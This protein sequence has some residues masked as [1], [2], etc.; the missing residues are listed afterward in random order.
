M[1]KNPAYQRRIDAGAM[2][3]LGDVKARRRLASV[4]HGALIALA[5]ST[6]VALA[7]GGPPLV[8]DDPETPGDGHWEINLATIASTTTAGRAL[9]APDAD[10][11]YGWGDRVQLKVDVPWVLAKDTGQ[12]WQSGIG[13]GDFGVK[14]RF[15]DRDREG[16]S[17]STYPQYI[18]SLLASSTNRGLA[19]PERQ[20]L[21]PLEAATEL[22]GF[23]WDAELGRNFVQGGASQWVVGMVGA[24]ACAT[25]V[26]CLIEIHET[27][28]P[29]DNQVLW[30]LGLRWKLDGSVTLLLAGGREF[31]VHTADQLQSL[32]YI[33]FQI[34]H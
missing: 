3:N 15:I 30:N 5:L 27:V 34:T 26:E 14:W 16:W 28:A 24:H 21:L 19:S 1:K 32:F 25:Q 11:N 13:A 18:R 6:S 4:L 2:P 20:F 31:G 9:T 7:Q 22:G 17:V 29:H 10:I 23:G 8:T 12:A 33:G